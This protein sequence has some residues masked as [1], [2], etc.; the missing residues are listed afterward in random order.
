M[1]PDAVATT[2]PD[3]ADA[4]VGGLTSIPEVP[5]ISEM[6]TLTLI[7]EVLGTSE[8]PTTSKKL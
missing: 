5:G 2:L 1:F 3:S 7:P 8:M 4:N 6:P